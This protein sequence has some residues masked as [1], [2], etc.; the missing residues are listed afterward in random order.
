MTAFV[1]NFSAFFHDQTPGYTAAV[2][3]IGTATSTAGAIFDSAFEAA[4]GVAGT[5]PSL[6]VPSADIVGLVRGGAVT[7]AG[8]A[9]T[10]ADLQPDG[11][12]LTRV[13]LDKA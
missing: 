11:T 8:T 7:V 12:G 13:V 4:L 2:L 5:A 1:E 10:V 6:L 9:Y 3:V